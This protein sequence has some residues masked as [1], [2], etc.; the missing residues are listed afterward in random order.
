MDISKLEPV[1]KTRGRRKG[2]PKTGGRAAGTPNKT[3][4]LLKDAILLAAELEGLDGNGTDG[5]VGYLRCIAR[6]DRKAMATLLGRV[7]P[8]Q[9]TDAADEPLEVIILSSTREDRARG[10]PPVPY[11]PRACPGDAKGY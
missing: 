8:T 7:L 3:T 2:T 5:L 4:R 6:E 1:R 10:V 11:I 9:L